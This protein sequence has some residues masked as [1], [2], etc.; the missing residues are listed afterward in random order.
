VQSVAERR[1]EVQTTGGGGGGGQS[2]GEAQ[3][4]AENDGPVDEALIHGISVWAD[5][6]SSEAAAMGPSGGD[7]GAHHPVHF[8]WPGN[9][10]SV[11]DLGVVVVWRRRVG[12]WQMQSLGGPGGQGRQ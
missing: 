2:F 4:A 8:H 9:D 3:S 5:A 11:V 10:L 7:R 1:E 6:A 12:A